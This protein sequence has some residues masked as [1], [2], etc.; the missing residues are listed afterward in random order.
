[1]SGT[2]VCAVTEDENESADALALGAELS[3]RLGL[4][5]VLAPRRRRH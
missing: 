4:R 5:L 3:E 2:L 1:M